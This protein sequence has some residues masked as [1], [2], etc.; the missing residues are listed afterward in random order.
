MKIFRYF[1]YGTCRAEDILITDSNYKIVQDVGKLT[2]E[3]RAFD[4]LDVLT[5]DGGTKDEQ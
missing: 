1:D 3:K 4:Y 5:M 2:Y